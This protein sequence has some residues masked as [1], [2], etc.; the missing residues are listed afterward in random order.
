MT[1]KETYG[2][3]HRHHRKHN[4]YCSSALCVDLAH[5]ECVCHAIE[6][7]NQHRDDGGYSHGQ[8]HPMYGSLCKKSKVIALHIGCKI[9]HI[10]AKAEQLSALFLCFGLR[11]L[12]RESF[13]QRG[14]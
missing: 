7:G 12:G 8:Y 1:K 13:E 3:Y 10:C 6:T 9:T 4:A 14:L 11:G 2:L 5:K